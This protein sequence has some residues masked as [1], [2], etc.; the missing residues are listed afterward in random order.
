MK[1]IAG[2]SISSSADAFWV[3]Q[4]EAWQAGKSEEFSAESF[5]S[6]GFIGVVF[7]APEDLNVE[8]QVPSLTPAS[9][10]PAGIASALL[11]LSAIGQDI[12]LQTQIEGIEITQGKSIAHREENIRK[13]EQKIRIARYKTPWQR[14]TNWMKKSFWGKLITNIVKFA[15]MVATIVASVAL[16]IVTFGAGSP[17][18]VCVIAASCLMIAETVTEMATDGKSIGEN[19]AEKATNN[20]EKAQKIAMA[21][22]ISI[23]VLEV[24]LSAAGGGAAAGKQMAS[25]SEDM[26]VKAIK[27]AQMVAKISRYANAAITL[28]EAAINLSYAIAQSERIKLNAAA[29]AQRT[30]MDAFSEWIQDVIDQYLQQISEALGNAKDAY[31]RASQAIQEQAEV[32][33]LIANNIAS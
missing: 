20:K 18:L 33:R 25:K 6:S 11:I 29:E 19:I 1:T 30:K 17:V 3:K 28:I 21:I 23:T 8:Y 10:T 16:T 5:F 12:A 31:E 4:L 15:V 2:W 32:A 26:A 13:L 24:G 27:A 9:I 7:H 14:L 22:D